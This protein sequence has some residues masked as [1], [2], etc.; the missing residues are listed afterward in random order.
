[1]KKIMKAFFVSFVLV[2]AITL[3][4]MTSTQVE[5]KQKA[6]V[7]YTLKK[8][9]LT[10]KGKGKM[11]KTMT[12]TKNKKIK[13][14]VIKKGVTSISNKAFYQCKN[15]K[16]VTIPKTVKEIGYLSFA[17]T[18]LTEITIPKSVKKIGQGVLSDNK[19]MSKI[20]IP[21]N[22]KLKLMP[23][24]DAQISLMGNTKVE[25]VKFNTNITLGN[26]AYFN[27][28]NLIAA[29]RDPNYKSINGV[30]YSKDGKDIVRVPRLRTELVIENGCENFNLKSILYELSLFDFGPVYCKDLTKV[31]IPETVKNVNNRKYAGTITYYEQNWKKPSEYKKY[32]QTD[33]GRFTRLT[34][35]VNNSKQLNQE[36]LDWLRRIM[37]GN[38]YDDL[39]E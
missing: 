3:V 13:K 29:K 31:T 2:F 14:V 7:T 19:K 39:F 27:T 1:M 9:T 15:L 21:G 33:S 20:T 28:N 11:P 30:V 5:A 32:T 38:S 34:E 37:K 18:K 17:G 4:P 10:I 23:E 12:F 35:C 36:S 22:F 26:I 8:G 16:K 24:D 6:K 25:T